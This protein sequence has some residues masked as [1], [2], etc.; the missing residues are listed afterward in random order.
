[1]GGRTG[2]GEGKE[3][4]ISLGYISRVVSWAISR[5]SISG[6]NGD[7]RVE[8]EIHTKTTTFQVSEQKKPM[9]KK[10]ALKPKLA[11]VFKIQKGFGSKLRPGLKSDDGIILI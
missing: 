11:T 3:P 7:L 10:K 6:S 9:G 8:L 2:E 5:L 1:L 4:R